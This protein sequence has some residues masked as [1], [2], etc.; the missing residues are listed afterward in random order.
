MDHQNAVRRPGGRSMQFQALVWQ[1]KNAGL[2]AF[3]WSA[4]GGLAVPDQLLCECIIA[5]FTSTSWRQRCRRVQRLPA[6]G[7]PP[8]R[9][10]RR[11]H[12]NDPTT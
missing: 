6:V 7:S 10:W 4:V 9:Q 2:N 5:R 3:W 11:N 8:L 1:N 12:T